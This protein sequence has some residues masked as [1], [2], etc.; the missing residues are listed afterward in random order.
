[1]HCSND[2]LFTVM[3]SPSKSPLRTAISN[4]DSAERA[5]PLANSAIA[6]KNL[7][8]MCISCAPNPD[9][10]AMALFNR[11]SIS[12]V[13]SACNTKTLHRDKRAPLISK[14]GFS[15]VAPIRI[16]LPFSTKGKKASCCALLKR[17]ISSTNKIVLSPYRVFSSAFCIT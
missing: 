16:I 6:A 9:G 1:M 17:C 4:V 14:D 8:A 2:S 15:V 12:S 13:D 10:S 7:S 5:S 11:V 3:T